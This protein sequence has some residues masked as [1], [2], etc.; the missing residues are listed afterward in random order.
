MLLLHPNDKFIS[1]SLINPS[2]G[3]AVWFHDLYGI[4]TS[5]FVEEDLTAQPRLGLPL[6]CAQRARHSFPQSSKIKQHT[7]FSDGFQLDEVADRSSSLADSAVG[8]DHLVR[9]HVEPAADFLMSFVWSKGYPAPYTPR[10]VRRAD[11]V[12][13]RRSPS[14]SPAWCAPAN[15]AQADGDSA[16]AQ[17]Y[18][19]TA[20]SWKS[21]LEKWTVTRTG[22]AAVTVTTCDSSTTA[23]PS[24]PPLTP[25]NG[26]PHASTNVRWRRRFPQLVRLGVGSP[27]RPRMRRQPPGGRSA[28]RRNDSQRHV[29]AP[30]H[31]RRVRRNVHGARGRDRPRH[32]TT[33]GR[34]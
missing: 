1:N 19:A 16:S 21:R 13:F 28:D 6:Q 33:H 8:A 22:P 27:L 14:G 30:L 31:R 12:P 20:N 7:G 26:D 11:A 4:V 32:F 18:L 25:R 24:P 3:P 15:I 34:L 10:E 9:R 29:L 5:T 2:G 17:L 23:M